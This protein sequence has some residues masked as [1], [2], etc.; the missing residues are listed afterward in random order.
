MYMVIYSPFVKLHVR[1]YMW[2]IFLFSDAH[3]CVVRDSAGQWYTHENLKE[4]VHS[5][6]AINSGP[7]KGWNPVAQQSSVAPLEEHPQSPPQVGDRLP[8]LLPGVPRQG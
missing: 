3:Y 1:K 6:N 4:M 2:R 5:N 7:G 8:L